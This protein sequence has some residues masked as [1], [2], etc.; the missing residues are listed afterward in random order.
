MK[1]RIYTTNKQ[2]KK[3]VHDE[4]MP[5]YEAALQDAAYQCFAIMMCVLHRDFG[6][7][8]K[9]LRKLKNSVEAE[10]VQMRM[11]VLG[12]P[13]EVND[14]VRFLK[15]KFDIDFAYSEYNDSWKTVGRKK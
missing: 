6:F 7:G 1:A 15:D 14:C 3:A 8:G 5:L 11:G 9:R 13:Y 10:Y 2:I 4:I 12:R